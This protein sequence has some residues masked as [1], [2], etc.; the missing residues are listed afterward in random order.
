MRFSVLLHHRASQ[1][2]WVVV[3]FSAGSLGVLTLAAQTYGPGRGPNVSL[4]TNGNTFNP[5]QVARGEKAFA[6]QCASC[7][8][9]ADLA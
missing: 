3:I 8:G 6:E 7:H 4:P 9:P 1:L 5:A 2:P